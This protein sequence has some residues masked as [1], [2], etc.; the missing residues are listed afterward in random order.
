MACAAVSFPGFPGDPPRGSRAGVRGERRGD[1]DRRALGL[2]KVEHG[3]GGGRGDG[4]R[5]PG[6]GLALSGSD[7]GRAARE[8]RAAGRE[9]GDPLA[10]LDPEAILRAAEDRGLMLQPDGAGFT[11]YLEGE[12][13]DAEHPEAEVTAQRLGGRR[14]CR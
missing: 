11:A 6:L 8:A 9:L 10:G 12:P 14:R 13:V 3:A 5:P 1:R 7:A 2:G 4:I